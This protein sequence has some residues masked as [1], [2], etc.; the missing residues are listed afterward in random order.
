MKTEVI[1]ELAALIHGVLHAGAPLDPL[2]DWVIEFGPPALARQ[3][4]ILCQE[5]DEAGMVK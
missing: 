4:E 1:A 2:V 5:L 3:L